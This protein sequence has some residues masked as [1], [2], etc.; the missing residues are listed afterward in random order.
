MTRLPRA[1]ALSRSLRRARATGAMPRQVHA[2]R[3]PFITLDRVGMELK[4]EPALRI[5]AVALLL[6]TSAHAMAGALG[7]GLRTKK[8]KAARVAMAVA[9]AEDDPKEEEPPPEPE[10]EPVRAGVAAPAPTAAAAVAAPGPLLP[11]L[12][13]VAGAGA[14]GDGAMA[15]GG[16]ASPMGS[17]AESGAPRAQ[18]VEPTPPR[19]LRRTPPQYPKA[20]RARGATGR[21]VLQ[22]LVDERG[23][24]AEVRV[25]EAEPA[26]VFD[27]AAIAAA[28]SWVFE[29]GREG[30]A[31]VQA[32]V[33]QTIRFE[34]E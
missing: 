22:L 2:H 28:R 18:S 20:A 13:P 30:E 7:L 9:P 23:R 31:R 15:L 10:P 33:R 17:P 27:E 24:V 12:G 8:A 14:G 4:G 21:V 11:G 19:V 6:A 32:W 29:P 1:L 16:G 3:T 26:G 25:V 5:L 34:L